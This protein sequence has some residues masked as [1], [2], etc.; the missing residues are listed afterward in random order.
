[1]DVVG[2]VNKTSLWLFLERLQ[3]GQQGKKFTKQ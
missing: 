2:E 3:C 1:M